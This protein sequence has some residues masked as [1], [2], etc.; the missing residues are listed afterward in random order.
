MRM[1]EL[2]NLF[3]ILQIIFKYAIFPSQWTVNYLKAIY[4]KDS[5]EDPNNYRGLAIAS[6]ISKLYCMILLQRLED[7]MIKNKIISPSQIGF[8]KGHRTSDHIYLLKTLVMKALRRKKKLFVAF[9]DFKKAYDTVDRK[10]LLK[11]LHDSGVQGK[12]LSNILSMYN[13]VSYSIKLKN[14]TMNP[15][16]SN[17]GLKQGCPL[18][19]LLFNIYINDI[20]EYLKTTKTDFLT[21]NGTNVNHF[22]YADDLVLLA[23]SKEELQELLEGLSKFSKDKELT[24]N[25]KKSV[26]MIFNKA[27]RKTT[28]KLLYNGQELEAVQTF[29]YLGVEIST[30]GSFSLGIKSLVTKAKKAMIPLFRTFVQFDIPFRQMLRLC[31]TLIEPILLYNAENWATMTR[32][33]IEVCKNNHNQIYERS[34]KAPSTVAQLKYLKFALGVTKQCPTMAVLGETAEVPLQLKAYHRMLTFWNRTQAMDDNTLVKKAYIDNVAD[35]TE[36][37]QTIQILNCSQELHHGN[38]TEAKF[39]SIAK[40]NL[41]DNFAKY[42]RNRIDDREQEKK[43]DLYSKYKQEHEIEPYLE[44]PAFRDRQRITKFLTSNHH[45]EIERGRYI[46]KLREE[47]ICKACDTETVEDEEHFLTQC[48]A[49]N[50]TRKNIVFEEGWT[51]HKV[52]RANSPLDITNYLK[53]ALLLRDKL[54]NF[55]VTKLS[56]CAMRMTI[57]RGKDRPATARLPTK[58]QSTVFDNNKMRI[59]RRHPRFSPYAPPDP[60]TSLSQT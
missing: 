27:G 46:D 24:V 31:N 8:Q 33:D 16:P 25:A 12:F 28:D 30:N 1:K 49:Y 48:P 42:W 58:L 29:T 40:K 17:L 10:I 21:V 18:S 43:L 56:L 53:M 3:L 26:V 51:A 39:P 36:W 19:P 59:S 32:K 14:G 57:S 7:Y 47:R 11:T 34:L 45:L 5:K 41:R 6:A 13:R 15:I 2:L 37:C 50:E 54:V 35:N 23:E 4:K 44:L 9:I 22:L 52:L 55:H 60:S 38:V 20:G